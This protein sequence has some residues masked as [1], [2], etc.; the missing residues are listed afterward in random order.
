MI[1]T[2]EVI[3]VWNASGKWH[4]ENNYK[5]YHSGPTYVLRQ[6]DSSL[7]YKVTAKYVDNDYNN[8]GYIRGVLIEI[9]E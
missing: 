6:F 3:G 5:P 8:N 4:L 1:A 2:D 9:N 7:I